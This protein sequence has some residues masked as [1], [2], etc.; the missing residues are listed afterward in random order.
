[1]IREKPVSMPLSW[2]CRLIAH[3]SRTRSRLWCCSRPGSLLALPGTS[4]VAAFH[5]AA[6]SVA[7]GSGSGV[8]AAR[9]NLMSHARN[10]NCLI[11]VAAIIL[12]AAG[13][14][15]VFSL[16]HRPV[17]ALH[18]PV[19]AESV[20]ARTLVAPGVSRPMTADT[21]VAAQPP[22][23]PQEVKPSY[24]PRW[25]VWLAVDL[26]ESGAWALYRERAM[27]FASLIGD[28]EPVVLFRQLPG[29]G[30]AKRYII[31]ILDDDRAPLD[32]FCKKLT[33]AGSSCNVMRNE[34]EP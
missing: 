20:A 23:E 6:A 22:T 15:T 19:V 25:G 9:E 13:A 30:S 32:K 27:R 17:V 16:L 1:M 8:L 14:A 3:S 5:A 2:K 10:F 33:A 4:R 7:R 31:A 34:S 11:V 18:R 24:V 28:R 29:R 12:A 21:T 26:S